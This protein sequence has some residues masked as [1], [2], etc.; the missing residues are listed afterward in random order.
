[1][2]T[3]GMDVDTRAYFT[4]TTMIIAIPTGVKIFSWFAT[5]VGGV[6]E[7][8]VP[9][10]FVLGFLFLFTVGG[11][12]G[13]ILANSG[14]DLVLHDTYFVVAHFHYVLSMGAVFG[15]F[16][17]FYHWM[18]LFY[19]I[20]YSKFW[21]QLHFWITFIGVNITFFPMH[22]LGLA[23]MPRRIPDYP[24]IYW[25]WNFIASIGAYISAL[26]LLIFFI[27]IILSIL[28]YFKIINIFYSYLFHVSGIYITSIKRAFL[29]IKNSNYFFNLD[30]N[31]NS[32]NLFWLFLQLIKI[33]KYKVILYNYFMKNFIKFY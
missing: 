26:G 24:D 9:M 16:A 27:L 19:G 11:L 18:G 22:F 28:E 2:Y 10:L 5:I 15:L 29:I 13:V 23:G 17:A 25:S 32:V 12:T 31:L 8:S 21:G 20:Y 7:F 1:M 6:L 14:I 30:Y 3:V 33:K 4:A